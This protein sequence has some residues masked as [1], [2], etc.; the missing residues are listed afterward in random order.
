MSYNIRI[1]LE[2]LPNLYSAGFPNFTPKP[3]SLVFVDF[4]AS[5]LATGEL[6]NTGGYGDGV[7]G[8]PSD[9]LLNDNH[10]GTAPKR[11]RCRPATAGH[12]IFLN[13]A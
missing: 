8:A 3:P 13:E 10:L 11:A 12:L 4:S 5:L 2:L 7:D 6:L 9:G 1:E